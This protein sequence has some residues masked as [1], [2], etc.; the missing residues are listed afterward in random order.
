[1]REY[2]EFLGAHSPYDRLDSADLRSLAETVDVEFF[3]SGTMIV[4]EGAEPLHEMSVIRTGSVQILDRGREVDLLTAGDTFGHVSVLSGLAPSMSVRAVEDTV[5]YQLPDPRNRLVH[6]E[7]LQYS[8]YGSVTARDRLISVGGAVDRLERPLSEVTKGVL[9]CEPTDSIRAVARE[10]TETGQSCAI[11]VRGDEIGIVTDDDFRRRVATGEIPVDQPVDT[12]ASIPALSVSGDYTVSAAY[13]RMVEFGIHHLVVTDA[14]GRPM[15]IARVVDI[16]ATDVSH[17]LVI[18]S[19]AAKAD[20]IEQLADA[21]RLLNPTLVEL[22][23]AGVPPMHLAAVLST[24][25]E[26]LFR[27]VVELHTANDE[28]WQSINPSWMLL[29]SLG[30]REPLPNSDLDT[31]VAWSTEGDEQV[32]DAAVLKAASRAIVEATKRCGLRPCQQGLNPSNDLFNRSAPGWAEAARSWRTEPEDDESVMMV[33]TMLDA[34]PLTYARLTQPLQSALSATP[35]RDAYARTLTMNALRQRPPAGFVRE[36]VVEHMGRRR[37]L[38]LKKAALRPA[39]S[40]ARALAFRAG[41]AS[42]STLKRITTARD[43]GLLSHPEADDLSSAYQ[44]C[45]GLVAE[46]QILAL[47]EHRQISSCLD[48]AT[49]TGPERR[50]LRDAF[51]AIKSVQ[52]RIAS[53][54]Y[55]KAVL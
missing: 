27:R 54:R 23:D 22:W 17:P 6:P 2:M 32:M 50:Q 13:L 40:L 34:R 19:A 7:V 33:S 37:S 25:N 4:P 35:G 48:P 5:C 30:R 21:A 28:L 55:D 39:A 46:H 47:R 29:G 11:F 3:A 44:H 49:I 12:I 31:A 52:D 42:G 10:I 14:R 8:H 41:D 53:D 45:F 15:G 43:S 18:R 38:N 20:T 24:M 16:A 1:M 26:A 9:W 51:R 36:F